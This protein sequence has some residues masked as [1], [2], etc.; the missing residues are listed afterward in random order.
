[1]QYR[2]VAIPGEG[3]GL[4][5]VTAA[6]KVLQAA[7]KRHN[8]SVKVDYAL[9]GKPA[10]DQYGSYLPKETVQLCEGADGIVF[11]AVNKGGLLELRRHFDFF[12]NERPVRTYSQLINKSSIKSSSLSNVDILFVR[13]LTSGIYFGDAARNKTEGYHTMFY[14]DAEIKRIA[15]VAFQRASNR[16]QLLTVAHK[17]NALPNLPWTK[18]VTEVGKQYPNVKIEPMLVDNLAMQLVI[19]P[20]RFD[21]IVA[22]NLFGDILSDIGGA[23]V[24]SIGLLGSASFNSEGLGLYEPVHGTAPD[25]AGKKIA[26]PMGAIA[27][28]MMM[29]QQWGETAAVNHLEETWNSILDR[30]YRTADIYTGSG[31]TLVSTDELVDLF[32]S[33]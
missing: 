19:N 4:E 7:A 29:L 9:L 11:G 1:M 14:S 5:V 23:I 3:I 22:G 2:I 10:F 30:G 24:G 17:E 15:E 16:K 32:A 26:N 25:I 33:Y 31:E 20:Q 21:V 28:I 27:S 18:L 6:L 13:E 8:F 12:A